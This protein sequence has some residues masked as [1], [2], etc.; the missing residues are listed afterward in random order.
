MQDATVDLTRAAIGPWLATLLQ[1][2]RSLVGISQ[3]DLARRADTSEA[4]IWRLEHGK[5]DHIDLAVVER[6]LAALG[7]RGSLSVQ[8][9]HL[10]DRVRQ[11]DGVHAVCNGYGGRRVRRFSWETVLEAMIGR[12][13]PRGWIDLL[14]YRVADGALLV[15]ETKS[16]LP[17]MGALQRS[18]AFYEREAP[19]VARDLGW[20]VR[21]VTV[22]VLALDTEVVARRLAD[23]RAIVAQ[24][25]PGD[26]RTLDAWIRDQRAPRPRGWTLAMID[27]ASRGDVW[28]RRPVVGSVRRRPAYAGYADAAARLLR[29]R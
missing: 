6:V 5:A 11:R 16:D 23:S 10:D 29:G 15:D 18:V 13:R 27:P 9:R 1:R 8:G 24:A 4:T 19:H 22:V 28:L 3:A 12:D 2:G 25:F 17:D 21:S 26:V 20:D 7:M 14:G